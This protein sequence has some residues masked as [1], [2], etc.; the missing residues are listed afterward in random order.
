MIRVLVCDP[1]PSRKSPLRSAVDA[2]LPE[3]GARNFGSLRVTS[4][5][6]LRTVVARMRE[7]FFDIIVCKID[8][9]TQDIFDFYREMRARGTTTSL[10]A[11]ADSSTY[12]GEAAIA[13]AS[14]FCLI[15]E[16]VDGLKRALG[17]S[18]ECA[19]ERQDGVVGL[20]SE[21]GVGNVY[22]DD[23]LFAESS[24]RGAV[25]HLPKNRTLLVRLTLQAL[26]ARL[27]SDSRFIKVGGSFIVNL[28]SV[29]SVGEKAL[30]FTDGE[31]IIVPVRARKAVR[32]SY[33]EHCMRAGA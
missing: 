14:G 20:R 2:A 15:D 23:I 27:S 32:D 26:Y 5:A 31:S 33:K 22:S 4:S 8:D 19:L 29:R 12:A 9:G 11:V 18:V 17:P 21:L 24:R 7:D 6:D 28:D 30:I 13:G 3:L 1:N 16:K 10:V 25:L